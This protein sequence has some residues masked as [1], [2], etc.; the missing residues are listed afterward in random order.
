[1]GKLRFTVRFI[2]PK[3][4]EEGKVDLVILFRLPC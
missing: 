3:C 4:D 1:M 2:P